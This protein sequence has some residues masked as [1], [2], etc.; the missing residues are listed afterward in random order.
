M[1]IIFWIV[2]FSLIGGVLSV[3]L[4]A[5]FLFLP[6]TV[7]NRLVPHLISFAI[8]SLLGA[9]FLGLLPHAFEELKHG[10]YH[11]IFL[12]VL[13]GLL[14][15]FVLEKLVLWRHCHTD[16]CEAHGAHEAHGSHNQN[17]TAGILVLIGDAVHN[18]V[19]GVL[20]CAAFLADFDLGVVTAI[21]IAAHEI[22]QEVGDFVVLLHSGFS[23]KK[24]LVYN[25]LAS[26]ATVA[27]AL[28]AYFGLQQMQA[29]LP[30]VLAVA[31]SSFIYVAVAD[32]IPGLHKRA[33]I[34]HTAQQ[35]FLIAAG[36]LTIYFTHSSMH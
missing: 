11:N 16:H 27:G 31:A 17:S 12:A 5:S 25:M 10:D 18:F 7:R 19:D 14:G 29:L 36:V 22:P 35:L 13:L 26:L 21:A 23:R 4:A 34:N 9:A 2:L 15:F 33:Q 30:W 32:L 28:L 8:G 24:A 20:I 3:L 1:D 6:E